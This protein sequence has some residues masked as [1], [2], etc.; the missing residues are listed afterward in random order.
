MNI[1]I[2]KLNKP[3]VVDVY[4]KTAPVYNIWGAVTESKAREKAVARAKIRDGESILEVA[5]GTGLTFFEILKANPNGENAGIDLTPAMLEKARRK[6]TQAGTANYQLATGDAYNLQF[7]DH[8]FDLLMNNY[9][10]DLLPEKDF[11]TVLA[12]FKRVL[13]PGGRLVLVNMTR[14]ERFYQKF[15]EGVYNFNPRWLGGCRGVL[16]RD[17]LKS[18]GFKNIE[19]EMISQ[20]GFPSEIISATI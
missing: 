15:W 6:A 5:V 1:S 17:Y 12:E 19:R 11:L 4:S 2:A 13:K 18:A 10:F 20:F 3:E 7:P 16:L 8:H 9:M 14:G